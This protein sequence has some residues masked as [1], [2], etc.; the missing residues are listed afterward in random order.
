[1]YTPGYQTSVPLPGPA[2][3]DLAAVAVRRLEK[4]A[5]AFSSW[6]VLKTILLGVP[7]FGLLPL[8]VWPARFR[9]Y[10]ADDAQ[11]MQELAEWSK[12]RGRRPAAVGP[13]L[14]AAED[15]TFR[16]LPW[17]LS[18]LLCIFVVG[19]FAIQYARQPL[20]LASLLDCTYYHQ[21]D[22][23]Q[24]SPLDRNEFLYRV[25]IAS[26]CLGFGLHWIQVRSHASDM[27]RFVARFNPVLAAESL[28]PVKLPGRGWSCFR[29]M[30]LLTAIV[31]CCYG[32]WWGIPMVLAGMA[33]RRYTKVTGRFLR[34]QL[35]GRMRQIAATRRPIVFA[36]PMPPPLPV[37][38]A[39]R[40]CANGRCLA[41]VHPQARF[42]PR[43]GSRM[44]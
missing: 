39:L 9:E 25:W 2:A 41:V 38:A 32:A 27:K 1:M 22:I 4:R 15:T 5:S 7:S 19:A 20:E 24:S 14:A 35:A 33:Q 31:L 11:A 44:V 36:P 23:S 10:A 26:L 16:P 8:L 42:C 3:D 43:C 21:L 34:A 29:P 17:I 37:S 13:L 30:W 12:Q 6:G 18:L 40:R 28:P